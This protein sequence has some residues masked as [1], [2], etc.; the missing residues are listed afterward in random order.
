MKTSERSALGNTK[1]GGGSKDNG[2]MGSDSEILTLSNVR[3]GG[4]DGG[5]KA[6][7]RGRG[8]RKRGVCGRD[9]GEWEGRKEGRKGGREGRKVEGRKGEY[10]RN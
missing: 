1:K 5:V 3:N 7:V 9:A 2:W 4:G 6:R 10:I 8:G